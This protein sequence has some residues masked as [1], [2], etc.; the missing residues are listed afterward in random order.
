MA[1]LTNATYAACPEQ[2]RQLVMALRDLE[3]Q[4][5]SA[6]ELHQLAQQELAAV[7][8]PTTIVEPDG[9]CIWCSWVLCCRLVQL[10]HPIGL[11]CFPPLHS[12]DPGG[13]H[14]GKGFVSPGA[15]VGEQ[16]ISICHHRRERCCG[17][18]SSGRYSMLWLLLG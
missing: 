6:Q 3:Q 1:L 9:G 17:P 4:A 12:A 10:T 16:G 5:A 11:M 13:R 14:G 7:G 18:R 2:S 15:H 8:D